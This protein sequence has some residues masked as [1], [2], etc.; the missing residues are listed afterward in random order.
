MN[1][2]DVSI[3]ALKQQILELVAQYAKRR[4]A[5]PNFVPGSSSVPVSGKVF[6]QD[7]LVN[8]VDSSLDFWLTSGR[9]ADLFEQRFSEYMGT[10]FA[11]LCN[12]GSS[13]NLLAVSA[14]TSPQLGERRLVDGDEVI[15]VAA[16]FPTTVNPIIQNRLTPV[17]VDVS[18]ATYNVNVDLIEEAISPRTRAIVLAHTL[19]N[20]FDLH[21]VKKLA[22]K[23]GLFLI[24][25]TCDA[26]GAKYG[27]KQVGSFGDLAT[28]SFYPAHHITMGE[29][30]SVLTSSARLRKVVESLRDWGRDCWCP[31]G[32][33]NTCGK[34]FGW[35][36]GD[37]PS[38][39][40]HKYTYSHIGYNLKI[41]DMQ[42]AVG[43]AQLNK[44]QSFV[45]ARNQ[46]WQYLKDGLNKHCERLLLPVPTLNSQPS[47][48]GF[49]I[50]ISEQSSFSRDQL[51][52]FLESRKVG[53]RLLF[54]GNLLKQP[55]YKGV[56]HRIG[57]SL[58]ATNVIA[59]KTFWIGVYPALNPT[60]LDYVIEQFDDFL[61]KN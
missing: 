3:D 6:D 27:G 24:E 9:F 43:L 60:I 56:P 54:G 15:T 44:L 53:T 37:L 11:L 21:G 25:D 14:L 18:L 7:E 59:E 31:P 57:S 46:N 13:A 30:G 33:D 58:E 61:T 4:H 17:F 48:F 32:K 51:V 16:G 42:A 49:P 45:N 29:G 35:T 47:W 38:G 10:K 52:H 55:A 34:R 36:L 20:P 19:G 26:V 41:T 8:L 22:D 5:T 1:D 50:T 12:S 39:Y 40:D 28:T 23:Y 2:E